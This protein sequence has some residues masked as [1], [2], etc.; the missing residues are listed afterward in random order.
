MTNKHSPHTE[1]SDQ[2]VNI[3]HSV[4]PADLYNMHVPLLHMKELV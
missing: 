2:I 4:Y 1:Y 3:G